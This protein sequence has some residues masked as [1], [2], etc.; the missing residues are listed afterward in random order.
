MPDKIRF[1]QNLKSGRNTHLKKLQKINNN[2]ARGKLTA[3]PWQPSQFLS[4]GKITLKNIY[5]NA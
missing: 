5:I 4:I 1:L 2:K 3:K